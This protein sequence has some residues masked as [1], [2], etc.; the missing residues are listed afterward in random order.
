MLMFIFLVISCTLVN[1]VVV[2]DID[3]SSVKKTEVVCGE[4]VDVGR[5]SFSSTSFLLSF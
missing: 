5:T 3:Y 2:V 1:Q 4:G